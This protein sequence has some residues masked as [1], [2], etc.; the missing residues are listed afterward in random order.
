MDKEIKE[1]EKRER[2]KKK[3][4]EKTRKEREEE[5]HRE[6]GRKERETKNR[7]FPNIPT[8]KSRRSKSKSQSTHRGLHV[9]TNILEFHQI[10]RG[11]EFFYLKY[12]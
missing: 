12:F 1:N 8:V 4:G 3:K 10:P 6:R 7:D 11:M 5:S 2:K 9:G